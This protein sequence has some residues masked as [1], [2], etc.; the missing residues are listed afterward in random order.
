MLQFVNCYL[1]LAHQNSYALKVGEQASQRLNF[2][3]SILHR[4]FENHLVEAGL[5]KD[6]VVLDLG[7]GNGTVTAWIASYVG[8][9]GKVIGVDN[10]PE[11]LEIA[12]KLVIPNAEFMCCDVR[13]LDLVPNSIDFV[14]CRFLLMHLTDPLLVIKKAL[15]FLKEGGVFAAQEPINSATYLYPHES[16]FM[17]KFRTHM[18]DIATRHGVDYDIGKKM[19]PLF[20]Q[21]GYQPIHLHFSQRMISI[22]AM[23]EL[24]LRFYGD[25]GSAAVKSG[26]I[27]EEDLMRQKEAIQDHP[28]E[29]GAYYLVP[30]QAHISAYKK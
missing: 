26:G 16:P 24:M 19:Y 5:K 29:E 21:A 1:L 15:H 9:K 27:S 20:Y 12:R 25:I 6:M 17:E 2:Q 3:N 13:D 4:D 23:K 22:G 18:H 28:E 11:Q 10:S 7:C 30:Q 8:T 14:C